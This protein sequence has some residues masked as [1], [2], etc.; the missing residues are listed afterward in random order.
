M[1]CIIQKNSPWIWMNEGWPH[2]GGIYRAFSLGSTGLCILIVMSSVG[3]VGALSRLH[4]NNNHQEQVTC[5]TDAS[6]PEPAK[7]VNYMPPTASSTFCLHNAFCFTHPRLLNIL[8]RKHLSLYVDTVDSH[9]LTWK[10]S[11]LPCIILT[12]VIIRE[13]TQ[14]WNY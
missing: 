8:S 14:L 6:S 5:H 7:Q 2:P 10:L 3:P 11:G 9:M 4:S 13:L 1:G 12:P